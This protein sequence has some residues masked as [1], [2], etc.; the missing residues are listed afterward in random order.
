MK[1]WIVLLLGFLGYQSLQ[2]QCSGLVLDSQQDVDQFPLLNCDSIDG[3]LEIRG[4]S[5]VNLDGLNSL[6]H[7]SNHI[8]VDSTNITDLDGLDSLNYANSIQILHCPLLENVM[9]LEEIGSFGELTIEECNT[10]DSILLDINLTTGFVVA[11]ND[12]LEFLSIEVDSSIIEFSYSGIYYNPQLISFHG[13]SRIQEIH[14]MTISYND[15]LAVIDAYQNLIILNYCNIIFNPS[16]PAIDFFDNVALHGV[17][18]SNQWNISSNAILTDI[19][20]PKLRSF[21]S[22]FIEWNPQLDYCCFL[23][24]FIRSGGNFEVISLNGNGIHCDYLSDILKSC[25]DLDPDNDLIVIEFDNCP[26]VNNPDQLDWDNDGI[27]NPCDNCPAISNPDQADANSNFIG[28]VCDNV[29]A[30]VGINTSDPHSALQLENGDIYIKEA[31][32]GIIIRTH[33]GYCFRLNIDENGVIRTTQITC[34]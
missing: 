32:R 31:S 33:Q 14:T 21:G 30:K 18:N 26:T 3:N 19:Q 11:H 20:V 8:I 4:F 9:L 6:R 10:L 16:L 15:A 28:D 13:L 34:P 23:A 5:I 17:P 2:A 29:N 27:G 12:E 7:V 24:D 22:L 25:E 1:I